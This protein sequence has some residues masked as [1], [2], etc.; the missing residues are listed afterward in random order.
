MFRP[1]RVG[2][3]HEFKPICAPQRIRFCTWMTKSAQ[4]G[5]ADPQL[6]FVTDEA[7]FHITGYVDSQIAWKRPSGTPTPHVGC[8]GRIELWPRAPVWKVQL[9]CWMGVGGTQ[10]REQ[11]SHCWSSPKRNMA[12]GCFDFGWRTSAR[13]AA[14]PSKMRGVLKG[15]R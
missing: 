5:L 3:V 6:Q 14:I 12:C 15:R 13:L 11:T 7:Y 10:R 2:V 4:D 8:L 9:A 1:Y